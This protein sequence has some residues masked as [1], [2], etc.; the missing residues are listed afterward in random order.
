MDDGWQCP[1]ALTFNR[2]MHILSNGTMV[3]LFVL[4][5]DLRELSNVVRCKVL[6]ARGPCARSSTGK[7]FQNLFPEC[8]YPNFFLLK[9][10]TTNNNWGGG[11]VWDFF[12]FKFDH[13]KSPPN[14]H[15][16]SQPRLETLTENWSYTGSLLSY[17]LSACNMTAKK[18]TRGQGNNFVLHF[19]DPRFH[20]EGGPTVLHV[21]DF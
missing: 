9:R 11:E 19:P 20:M 6:K 21:F 18:V 17:F 2:D 7:Y 1:T 3:F 8:H 5:V 10:L 13:L 4:V 14:P 15:S 16:R 12:N